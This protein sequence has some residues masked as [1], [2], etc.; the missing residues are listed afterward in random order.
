VASPGP[1][2]SAAAG[3]SSDLR[4]AVSTTFDRGITTWFGPGTSSRPPWTMSQEPALV[5][6]DQARVVAVAPDGLHF[7]AAGERGLTSLYTSERPF[8]EPVILQ[9][10]GPTVVALAFS[11]RGDRLASASIDGTVTV[12]S[13]GL[14]SL[15][16]RAPSI[17]GDRKLTAAECVSLGENC[18]SEVP[19]WKLVLRQILQ[20]LGIVRG[21]M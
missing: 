9:A 14:D 4:F 19:A 2:A 1:R 8:T 20:S 15:L 12:Y 17:I 6:E 5:F 16:E 3:F 11:T 13:F 18:S 7:A 21:A 10:G